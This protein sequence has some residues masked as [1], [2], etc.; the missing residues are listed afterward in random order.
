MGAVARY[1][2]TQYIVPKGPRDAKNS[3]PHASCR[4]VGASLDGALG[5]DSRVTSAACEA[6]AGK[7]STRGALVLA[8]APALGG[9]DRLTSVKLGALEL[10]W[11]PL[12]LDPAWLALCREAGA[13]WLT[14][15]LVLSADLV[16]Q[17][18]PWHRPSRQ[19]GSP[20]WVETRFPSFFAAFPPQLRA[21][22]V[23]RAHRAMEKARIG[24]QFGCDCASENEYCRPAGPDSNLSSHHR[25]VRPRRDK[26][27]RAEIDWQS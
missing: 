7:L 21:P 16:H 1:R 3:G 9:E 2:A 20:R 8:A 15:A 14:R 6:D 22:Q 19:L 4:L 23:N 25:T 27:W 10:V 11:L 26:P 18:G 12:A 13:A 24:F 17:R 5:W